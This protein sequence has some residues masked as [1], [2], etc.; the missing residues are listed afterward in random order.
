MQDAYPAG[1]Q[2]FELSDDEILISRSDLE[3]NITYANQ[4]LIDGSGIRL[5]T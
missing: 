2:L 5:M 3:G 4:S 1:S